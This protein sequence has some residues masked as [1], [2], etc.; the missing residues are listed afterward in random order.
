M[1]PITIPRWR[2]EP[3]PTLAQVVAGMNENIRAAEDALA[4]ARYAH[5]RM[6]PGDAQMGPTGEAIN[7]HRSEAEHWGREAR[8]W[9]G[10]LDRHPDYRDKPGAAAVT[11]DVRRTVTEDELP[12]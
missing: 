5:R 7:R 8:Y 6:M 4:E 1:K 3:S 12:F 11:Y 10:M 9:R 2:D